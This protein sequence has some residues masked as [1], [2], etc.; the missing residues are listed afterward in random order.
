MK[1]RSGAEQSSK[2]KANKNVAIISENLLHSIALQQH[3]EPDQPAQDPRS[4][5][6]RSFVDVA[7]M[8][9]LPLKIKTVLY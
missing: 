2:L 5:Q 9:L 3:P 7:I 4:T 1:E 8:F 6:P